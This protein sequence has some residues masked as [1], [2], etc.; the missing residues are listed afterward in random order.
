MGNTL[1][2]DKIQ[3]AKAAVEEKVKSFQDFQMQNGDTMRSVGMATQVAMMRD[4]L[5]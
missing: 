1:F 2:H 5:Q 3:A 4:Q